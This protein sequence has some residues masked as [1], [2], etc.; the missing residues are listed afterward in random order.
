MKQSQS[1]SINDGIFSD[2]E[3]FPVVFFFLLRFCNQVIKMTRDC[4]SQIHVPVGQIT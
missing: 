3:M 4:I 1:C 2:A